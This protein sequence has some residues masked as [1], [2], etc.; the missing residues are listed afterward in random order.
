[1]NKF[2]SLTIFCP[3]IIFSQK[4]QFKD[5]TFEK[6]I[7]SRYDT[8]KNGIIDEN[9]Y[10]SVTT[11]NL[12]GIQI[13]SYEDVYLFRARK[14]ILGDF[15]I[16]NL[17]IKNHP[18]LAIIHCGNCDLTIFE[19]EN[20]PHL[21]SIDINSNKLKSIS[22]KDCP[23]VDYLNVSDNNISEINVD[24]LKKLETLHVGNNNLKKLDV[25]NL[26][27][28]K[29]LTVEGNYIRKL[30]ISKNSDLVSVVTY[31]NELK[32]ADII[33]PKDFKGEIVNVEPDTRIQDSLPPPPARDKK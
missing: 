31:G 14:L 29:W 32:K 28:L 3:L 24:H 4:I 8:N 1:M 33:K 27:K 30:D 20:I 9:E 13:E 10:A 11:I 12:Q 21:Y 19:V 18:T 23:E 17:I 22:V 7:L 2:L 25:Q 26:P 15:P 16:K 5:K 6:V